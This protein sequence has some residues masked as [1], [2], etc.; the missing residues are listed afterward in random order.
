MQPFRFTGPNVWFRLRLG[1]LLVL[2]FAAAVV[3]E[4]ERLL[5]DPNIIFLMPKHGAQWI[6][7]GQPTNLFRWVVESQSS[8]FRARFQ[9]PAGFTGAEVEVHALREV[10]VY[11]D[12]HQVVEAEPSPN[13]KVGH[14]IEL[15]ATLAAGPHTFELIVRNLHGPALALVYGP[16]V[17][18]RSGASWQ[19]N[20]DG[21]HWEPVA[22]A[23]APKDP[24]LEFLFGPC[25]SDVAAM[26]PLL[27]MLF[28]AGLWGA[29]FLY[30]AGE[31]RDW[32]RWLR[33]GLLVLWI[34]FAINSYFKLPPTV[35]YDVE[36]HVNYI[37]FILDHGRLPL[38]NEGW[39]LFQ[40]PF[41]YLVSALF[42]RVIQLIGISTHVADGM[43]RIVTLLCG[44]GIVE[45][46]YRSARLIFRDRRDLQAVAIIMGGL[47]PMNLYM[48][49]SISNEPM[50]GLLGSLI[51]LCSFNLLLFP[52][53]AITLRWQLIYGGL[54][55]LAL[56]TKITAIL[57]IPAVLFVLT[58]C[59]HRERAGIVRWMRAISVVVVGSFLI[60]SWYF[61]HNWIKLGSPFLTGSQIG[62]S[63]P[64]QDPGFRTPHQFL[65]F[66]KVFA[67]PLFSGLN[68][69]W[70]SLYDTFWVDGFISGIGMFE[71]R[72]PW[73]YRLMSCGLWLSV[74]PMVAI[75]AGVVRCIVLTVRQ[76]FKETPTG[77][78]QKAGQLATDQFAVFTICS[79]IG[80]V[81]LQYLK[82]PMY[83]YGKSTYMLGLIPCFAMLGASGFDMLPD[84][85]IMR[86]IA[87]GLLSCWA[88]IAFLTYWIV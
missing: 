56:L 83:S 54:L 40:A 8:A 39:E 2:I 69:I 57:W 74:F 37:H 17:N 80:A 38:P 82:N 76:V 42:Y 27:A 33:W 49:P 14:R 44:I 4:G 5:D 23:D 11:I 12:R 55:G 48:A 65:E 62:S 68:S 15:P 85:R 52:K 81:A 79:F 88:A 72:P 3:W 31:K 1:I 46:C 18:L 87:A 19:V 77:G 60:C 22:L 21:K 36:G 30:R 45:I 29:L 50:A 25:A 35:G 16:Q 59:F 47:M 28:A 10:K 53:K 34:F 51:A 41:F 61:I 71:Y 6:Q 24:E 58:I 84:R 63:I 9:V 67:R 64:L 75:I 43:L 78:S 73:N 26:L 32:L 13:W 70:D 86:S 66:G 7:L 20:R